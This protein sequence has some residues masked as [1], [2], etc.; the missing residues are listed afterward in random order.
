VV[1]VAGTELSTVTDSNG[2]YRIAGVPAGDQQLVLE[3]LGDAPA[4]TPVS[5]AAETETRLT[6][7]RTVEADIVV[8]GYQG[9]LQKSLNQQKNAQNNATIISADLL[10][11]F[12]AET[13]S[14]ALRRVPGVAFGRAA[15]TG[16]GSRITVRGFTS[17]AIQV[18]L[19]GLELQGTGFE[20]TIDLSGYLAD[21][22]SEVR[23]EKSLTPSMEA[24]GSG[25]LVK[26]ETKSGLDYGKFTV[27]LGVEG[28]ANARK[29]YGKEWQANGIIGGKLTSNL[30]IAATLSY[31]TTDRTN[32]DAAI[33]TVTPPVLPAGFTSVSL[34]PASRDFPFDDAFARQ[35]ITSTSYSRRD[36]D[37][38]N[39]LASINLAWDVAP[40][41]R[42][43]LDLQRNE[44]QAVT[45]TPRSTV[46]FLTSAFDMPIPE[47]DNEVRRRTVI[48]SFRPN[49]SF[50]KTDLRYRSDTISLR[51]HSD[52]GRLT[53]DYKLGWQRAVS[54][55]N[56]INMSMLGATNTGLAGLVDPGPIVY[57]PDDDA[58]HTPR[59]V[60]GIFVV[61]PNGLPVPA[62]TALGQSTLLNA[63]S[64]TVSSANRTLTNSPSSAWTMQFDGKYE[65]GGFV[66]YI[67]AGTK[68]DPST[69]HSA[70]D[71]FAST[72][73]GS[74]SSV[75]SYSP[76]AGRPTTLADLGAGFI[77]GESLGLLGQTQ[78]TIP[79]LTDP[80]GILA[81]IDHFRVDDPSTPINEARFNFS[82]FRSLDPL[83]DASAQTP[84]K[85]VENK[86][87]AYVEGH[88]VLGKFDLTTGARLERFRRTGTTL[89]VPS[90]TS[91]AG[92]AEPRETFIGAGLVRYDD[93]S[94]TQYT[95]TPS[96][97]LNYRPARQLV[98]RFGYFHS[99]V[100]PDFRLLRRGTQVFLDLRP[101]QNRAVIREANPDLKA[102]TAHN[103]DLDLA[104]YFD[105]PA[106]LVRVGA[107]YKI[108]KNNF[109][110]VFFE[111]AANDSVRAR[112]LE[113]FGDLS[114]T[115]PDLF[116]FD[117][118]TRFQ[119]NRPENGEGGKIWGVE[120]ELIKQLDFLPGFLAN[121]N[122]LA[123]ATYTTADF[124]T[125]VSGRDDNGV[126]T[127]FSLD[128]PLADQ[129]EWVYNAS[130]SYASGGFEARLI[131]THQAMSVTTYSP[132]DLNT[133][134]PQY[135]TL[136]LRASY[137][138]KL[139]GALV[140]L[141]L[142]GDDLLRGS[143]E[144]D[145]RVAIG[146]TP[147][148][149]DTSYLFPSTLQFSGGRT[150]TLGVRARF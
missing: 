108:V 34:I 66:D 16:E 97:L 98:A 117:E 75:V 36:R 47:L 49:L 150:V 51:G 69:R 91:A 64:F 50:N 146:S 58:A 44:R 77:T 28:E 110:N 122:V 18:Q 135:S 78:V 35:L 113:F 143:R 137:T 112:V 74:L 111:D 6:L 43:R 81:R 82:D 63:S 37:E 115:R 23:I 57:N 22:I 15:D 104:Y 132:I 70:D 139:A 67:K 65:F 40:S 126:L 8:Y 54:K 101:S 120:L 131:Y 26:I 24:G 121:F 13:V 129:S 87:A 72:S 86:L 138:T 14:E 56:N 107:F 141:Y 100:N 99:T 109:T 123:N 19:N 133:V 130:L 53:L 4:P 33:G 118:N 83:T 145:S 140:T 105:K 46:S 102:T 128:K 48:S 45:L 127:N 5:V 61:L 144:P 1:R 85:T 116:A 55:S 149:K 136:D 59:V 96:L 76:I 134:V 60:D 68:Y 30:G 95:I 7:T 73:T 71:L 3:Y 79:Y 93:L 10:G 31:R 2:A 142:Q 29:A 114:T 89:T 39:L 103:F 38:K 11:E 90:I 147:G 62:F 80:E 88:F 17:E 21:N 9:S 94:G 124:P 25:G 42:L 106:G 52:L 92:I 84:V 119:L 12:P 32:Y 20:R 125:L 148:R 27:S 41:T